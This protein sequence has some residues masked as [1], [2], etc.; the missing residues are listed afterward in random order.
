MRSTLSF[1]IIRTYIFFIL[2]RKINHR[3]RYFQ[4]ILLLY[5]DMLHHVQLYHRNKIYCVPLLFIIYCIVW[6]CYFTNWVSSHSGSITTTLSPTSH[7]STYSNIFSSSTAS[8]TVLSSNE[9]WY[10]AAP[11]FTLP[12]WPTYVPF[13]LNEVT[14]I[15]QLEIY[16]W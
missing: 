1:S 13:Q 9:T 7:F 4:L 2:S 3:H 6:F 16:C 10:V 5:N 8:S 11:S 12:M 14:P 15:H